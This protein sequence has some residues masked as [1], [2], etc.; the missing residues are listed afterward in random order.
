MGITKM[1]FSQFQ[2]QATGNR[3]SGPK[4]KPLRAMRAR[5]PILL[6]APAVSPGIEAVF[7]IAA[8]RTPVGVAQPT[9]DLDLQDIGWNGAEATAEALKPF[10]QE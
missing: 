5:P 9:G 7:R 8:P 10:W 3:D 2:S 1:R 6:R 4:S